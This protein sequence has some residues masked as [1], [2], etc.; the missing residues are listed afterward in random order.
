LNFFAGLTLGPE[1]LVYRFF[2]RCSSKQNV[3]SSNTNFRNNPVME[4]ILSRIGIP[5]KIVTKKKGSFLADAAPRFQWV[6]L[7]TPLDKE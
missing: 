7:T 6:P 4:N 1:G 5:M 2:T 3:I